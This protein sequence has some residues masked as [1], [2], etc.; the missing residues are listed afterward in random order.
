MM[1]GL[2][3]RGKSRT[4]KITMEGDATGMIHYGDAT[5]MTYTQG[6]SHSN[7]EK[8]RKS[9]AV[10]EERKD[11]TVITKTIVAYLPPKINYFKR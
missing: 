10:N 3:M 9:Y 4:Y 2:T 1:I 11:T 8:L 7:K 5:S 6:V